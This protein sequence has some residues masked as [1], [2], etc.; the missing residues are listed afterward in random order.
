VDARASLDALQKRP[1]QGVKPWF[2]DCPAR[3]LATMLA[4]S[5]WLLGKQLTC[6]TVT[7]GDLSF[8]KY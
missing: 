7:L 2:L 1:L 6:S 4:T 3:K 5:P 8:L